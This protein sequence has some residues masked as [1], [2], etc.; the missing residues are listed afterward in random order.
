MLQATSAAVRRG[1][2]ISTAVLC[3]VVLDQLLWRKKINSRLLP[4]A[5]QVLLSCEPRTDVN[6]PCTLCHQTPVHHHF[7]G[8]QLLRCLPVLPFIYACIV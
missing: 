1:R 5:Q 2:S 3:G 4:L 6:L 8:G 7:L